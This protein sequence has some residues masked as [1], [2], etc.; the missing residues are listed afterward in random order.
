MLVSQF[1]LNTM[2]G[3]VLFWKRKVLL[4][5]KAGPSAASLFI[6]RAFSQTDKWTDLVSFHATQ[7]KIK[8]PLDFNLFLAKLYLIRPLLG[9]SQDVS[10]I[11]I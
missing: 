9:G 7:R 2:K 1:V 3:H 6:M 8:F 4:L 11:R 10:D 5:I